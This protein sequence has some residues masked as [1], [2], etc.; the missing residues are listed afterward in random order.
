MGGQG[1]E[2]IYALAVL[3]RDQASQLLR[4]KIEDARREADEL[5]KNAQGEESGGEIL[6]ALTHYVQAHK[7]LSTASSDLLVLRIIRGSLAAAI[8]K[9]PKP[10]TTAGLGVIIENIISQIKL[11][12][13]SGNDQ[14]GEP[15]KALAEPLVVKAMYDNGT[16]QH[17]L[18][19]IQVRFD[20]DQGKGNLES[21]SKADTSGVA[22]CRVYSVE[23]TG[24]EANTIVS[25]MD[26][27]I[28]GAWQRQFESK[29]AV[30]K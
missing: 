18:K 3:D 14:K 26:P 4:S 21:E 22:S 7:K 10:I 13:V 15:G 29:K 8:E 24:K 2:I 30:L 9:E 11:I 5:F 27:G 28:G 16:V 25:S 12:P 6:Q 1:T 20:F 19:G 17:P 23:G